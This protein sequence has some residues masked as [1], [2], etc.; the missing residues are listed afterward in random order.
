MAK[1]KLP[2][3]WKHTKLRDI[4]RPIYERVGE[5]KIE[6]LSISAGIGFVNQA[7]KFGRELSGNQYT[8]YTVLRKGDFSFNKGNSKKYPYG[9]IY[10]LKDREIA[11]VPNAFYSFYIAGQCSEFYEQLFMSGCLNHQLGKFINTGVRNDGLFNLYENDFYECTVP[12]PPFP[13]QRAI[14]EILITAD[15]IIDAKKRLVTAKQKQKRWLM[16][17]LLT[18][19][20]RLPGFSGKW[21]ELSVGKLLTERNIQAPKN[22]NYP[23]MAFIAN[24]G[25]SPKGERYD[26]SALILDEE[27]KFYKRTELGDFIYSS[28]NLQS[29]SIGLNTYGSASI[30]PVYSIFKPTEFAV[31]DFIGRF[32]TRKEFVDK[33]VKWRQGVIY[34]QWRIHEKDFLRMKI[35]IPSLPEQ[36]A[37]AKVLTTADREIELLIKDLEQQKQTKK[38]LMQ[39]LLTGKIRVKGVK[40][41]D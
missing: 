34:G 21:V 40:N 23:L 16:Q 28:N 32:L 7:K 3:G 36:Q 25:I 41:D 30:S 39:Q 38:Y 24:I 19:K 31:S 17:N 5:R 8:K 12:L 35:N 27:N 18:G 26:R 29:G 14:A 6:T 20:M 10:L 37:I 11:S 1:T 9:C 4:A 2:N 13:E 33:M 15:K 22:E